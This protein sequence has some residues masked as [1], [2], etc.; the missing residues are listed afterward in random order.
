M[1]VVLSFGFSLKPS[2]VPVVQ[3]LKSKLLFFGRT[4]RGHNHTESINDVIWGGTVGRKWYDMTHHHQPTAILP[5]FCCK[6]IGSYWILKKRENNG[7]LSNL[8]I[9]VLLLLCT[10]EYC[11]NCIIIVTIIFGKQLFSHQ[12]LKLL[13]FLQS[14][15]RFYTCVKC[16][17]YIWFRG[18]C[19]FF[20]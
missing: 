3:S 2:G 18:K 5:N 11:L 19:I 4:W 14:Q 20:I 12:Q 17:N 1:L 7:T 13:T 8:I 10:V 16:E 6:M 9:M 15:Y